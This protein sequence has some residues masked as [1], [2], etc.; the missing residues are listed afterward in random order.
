MSLYF[1][2]EL[3]SR[4]R[5]HS[6]ERLPLPKNKVHHLLMNL[7]N[8]HLKSLSDTA[9]QC[10]KGTQTDPNEHQRVLLSLKIKKRI[11][12]NENESLKSKISILER[13]GYSCKEP[14]TDFTM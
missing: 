13:E 4:K 11:L 1:Q 8:M 6:K 3:F 12:R 7:N 2:T 9:I 14:L 10:H 5:R